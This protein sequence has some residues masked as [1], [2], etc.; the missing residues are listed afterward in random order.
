MTNDNHN[1][2]DNP[3]APDLLTQQLSRVVTD[4]GVYLMKDTQGR[5]LYVGKARNLKKRLQSYFQK[6]RPHDPKTTMLLSKVAGFDT[7]VTRTEKEALILESNLIKRHRPRYNVVLKDD[8]RYPSLKLNL[9]DTYPNLSIVRKIQNDGS[10]YF[11]PYASAGAVRQTLKFIHKTFKL[12]KCNSKMFANRNRPCL[13]YQMGMCLGPC[14]RQV[15]PKDYNEIV[16]EVISFLR[17]RT[18]DLIRKVEKQMQEAASS[19]EFE[20][21]AELRNKMFAL[22]KTLERQVTV[23]TDLKDRD[24]IGMTAD[25]GALAATLL[26]VRGGFLL[27]SRHFFF[28]ETIG[29][30]ADQMGAFLRQ[31]YEESTQ[32]IPPEIIVSDLPDD[33]DLIESYLSEKRG[34][35]VRI[36]GPVR[37]DKAKLVHIAVQNAVHALTE[38]L[39][40]EDTQT[41]LLQRLQKKLKLN[42]PPQRIECF[43]NSNLAGTQPVSGMVVFENAQPRNSAYRHYILQ[44]LEKPDDYANMAEV[45]NRRYGKAEQSLPMPD[46]LL[47]DGGKGQLNIALSVLSELNLSGSF[48][49]AG[50]AKK[51]LLQGETQ[52]KIYLAGRANPVQFG[53]DTDLLMFL[54]RIRD[55]AHRW[56]ISFQRVRRKK[57]SLV[58]KLDEIPGIGPR[59][60][61]MLLKHFGSLENIANTPLEQLR[62]LPGI[63]LKTAQAIKEGIMS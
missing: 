52:D 45:L 60:K 9:K 56:A 63:S 23:S 32:T 17:G 20:K 15:D 2:P 38:Y 5:I 44:S 34:T 47:V 50:I 39:Q 3:F 10:L 43:D 28:N 11:G 27:G 49:V 14:C 25:N 6:G 26:R 8:K 35:R 54:Q 55:E 33:A 31:Y 40:A 61:A 42:R 1:L 13:N 16:K 36:T 46:L 12:R 51:D 30:N 21:A 59:R 58:S 48:D 19:H 57:A 37:G 4:P 7:I 53:R 24:V 29:S 41:A 62:A 22:Q 18:P